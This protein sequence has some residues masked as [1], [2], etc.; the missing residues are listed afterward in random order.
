YQD[1]AQPKQ[2]EVVADNAEAFL[3]PGGYVIVAIKARSIDVTKEP[4]EV[5]EDEERKL[6][7]RGFEV[8]EVIE[9]P[10]ETA[11]DMVDRGEIADSITVIALLRLARQRGA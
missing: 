8:L 9:V 11:L 10:V 6:E 2:A 1:I 4:E 5:F 7:E 3:R